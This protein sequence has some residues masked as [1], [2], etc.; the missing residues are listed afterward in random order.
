MA[1]SKHRCKPKVDTIKHEDLNLVFANHGEEDKI[2]P[3]TTI[4]IAKAHKKDQAQKISYETHAK[5]T[6]ALHKDEN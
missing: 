2:Y 4:E 3:L 5:D 6:I 1:V